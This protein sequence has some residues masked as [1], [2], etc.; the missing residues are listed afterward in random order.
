[1]RLLLAATLLLPCVA[2]AAD[3]PG[4][5]T[6]TWN[7]K[8]SVLATGMPAPKS[9]VL[10]ITKDDGNHLAWSM[11]TIDSKGKTHTMSWSGAYDGKERPAKGGGDAAFTKGDN[12]A[13]NV[14]FKEK[15]GSSGKESCTIS[16]DKKKMTCKGTMTAKDGKTSDYT[17]V[18]DR[19]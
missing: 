10:K 5:A 1:M 14:S 19:S 4:P 8:E 9:T 7:A 17:D 18:Y 15:D 16:D 13:I 2:V 6:W 11:T 12:G 3:T